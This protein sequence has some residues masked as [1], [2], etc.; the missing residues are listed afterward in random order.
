MTA[1][2]VGL[3]WTVGDVSPEGFEALR[4]AVWGAFRVF[5]A[6]ASYAVCVNS[7]SVEEARRRAG[8]LPPS[9][10]WHEV[11]LEVPPFLRDHLDD[12]M[13]EG[14]AW[15]FAPLRMFP[16]RHELS[17]DNDCILWSMPDAIGRW[18][19]GDHGACLLAEDVRACFGQFAPDCGSAPLNAGIRGFPPGFD[20]ADALASVLRARPVKLASELDEQGLQVAALSRRTAPVVVPLRDVTICSPFPPHLP[21]LGLCGAHFCGLN[22]R[23]L[24]WSYEGR[25]ASDIVRDHFDHHRPALHARV[26]IGREVPP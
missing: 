22:S 7:I 9:C 13:A 11:T 17:F 18:L 10:V 15:K 5:G 3:R 19:E 26:G 23:D 25:R 2:R 8:E 21:H 14:V 20:V 16:D 6:G 1:R 12:T 24:G 4:L